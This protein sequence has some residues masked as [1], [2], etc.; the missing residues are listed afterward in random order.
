VFVKNELAPL[1][2]RFLEINDWLGQEV[3]AFEPY[4]L[5]TSTP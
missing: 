1:Q 2:A 4:E 3:V 5:P